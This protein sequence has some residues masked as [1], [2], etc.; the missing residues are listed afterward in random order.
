MEEE[1]EERIEKNINEK[2]NNCY[3]NNN[4]LILE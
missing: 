4:Y 3:I 2:I 1:F